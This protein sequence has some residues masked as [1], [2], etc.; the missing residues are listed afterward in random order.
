[1][2]CYEDLAFA[3]SSSGIFG[4]LPGKRFQEGWIEF[5]LRL[6]DAQQW[7]RLRVMQKGKIRKHPDCTLGN[8]SCDETFFEGFV[9]KAEG[10]APVYRVC[11]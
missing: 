6:L 10:H 9:A 4:E 8:R 7:V 5:V 11:C 3:F 2:R 1:M